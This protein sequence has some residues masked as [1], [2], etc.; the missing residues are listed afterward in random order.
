MSG[1]TIGLLSLDSTSLLVLKNGGSTSDRIHATRILPLVERKHVLLVTLLLCNAGA[2][3]SGA[4]T[5]LLVTLL[6]CNAGA[7]E[8]LPVFLGH[9]VPEVP[10]ILLSVT[11][12]LLFGEIIPQ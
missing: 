4:K 5:Q 10:A 7:M 6:L 12:V 8:A 1:L 3:G 9:M 2:Y 11:A